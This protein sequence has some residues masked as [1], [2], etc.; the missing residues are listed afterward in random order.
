MKLQLRRGGATADHRAGALPAASFLFLPRWPASSERREFVLLERESW[1]KNG[2][3]MRELVYILPL[4]EPAGFFD[5]WSDPLQ[6]P[7]KA[8]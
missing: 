8:Q 4:H 7:L 2:K 5:P 1:R 6:W 3:E